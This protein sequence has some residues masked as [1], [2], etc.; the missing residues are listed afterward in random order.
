MLRSG[1]KTLTTLIAADGCEN[2]VCI[3][4]RDVRGELLTIIIIIIMIIIMIIIIIII[5]MM[6]LMIMLMLK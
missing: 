2:Q 3:V 6:R 4:L 1:T 5:V